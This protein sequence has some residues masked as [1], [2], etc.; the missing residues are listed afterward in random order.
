[1]SDKLRTLRRIARKLRVPPS[2]YQSTKKGKRGYDRRRDKK[3][4]ERE[5][6]RHE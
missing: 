3:E 5:D 6:A 1:M 4:R 2:R